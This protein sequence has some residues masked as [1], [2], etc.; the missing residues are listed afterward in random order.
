MSSQTVPAARRKNRENRK[1]FYFF[2]FFPTVA[3]RRGF[4]RYMTTLFTS[5]GDI[6]KHNPTQNGDVT[7]GELLQKSGSRIDQI[8][9]ALANVAALRIVVS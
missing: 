1:H 5:I 6:S 9:F 2:K 3:D 8:P 4:L 7:H